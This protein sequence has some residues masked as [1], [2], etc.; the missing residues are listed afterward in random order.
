M[1]GL[2]MPCRAQNNN[3]VQLIKAI[4]KDRV[5]KMVKVTKALHKRRVMMWISAALMVNYDAPT[6]SIEVHC[7]GPSTTSRCQVDAVQ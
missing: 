2:V 5:C 4:C 6:F 7:Q 1:D 3:C